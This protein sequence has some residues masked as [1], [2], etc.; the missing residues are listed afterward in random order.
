MA[1]AYLC[2]KTIRWNGKSFHKMPQIELQA[3][4]T[5]RRPRHFNY[6]SQYFTRKEDQTYALHAGGLLWNVDNARRW[7][8]TMVSS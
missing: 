4:Q 2:N 5:L 3:Q 1:D 7:S 8:L 6:E